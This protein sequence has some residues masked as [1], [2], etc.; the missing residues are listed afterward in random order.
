MGIQ[1]IVIS[2]DKYCHL[3]RGFWYQWAKYYGTDASLIL[4]GLTNPRQLDS[5]FGHRGIPFYSAGSPD[6]YPPSRWSDKLLKILD[7]VAEEVFVLMLEDYWLTRPVDTRAIKMIY[8]YMFQF[9]NVI[10]F[11]V[12]TERLFA[13]GGGQYLFGYNTY[14]TLGYLDLIKSDF[15]SPYHLSLWGGMWRRD[16]LR[17]FLVIGETAQQ[18]ELNGTHRLAQVGD[19]LLVLGTR[20]APLKHANVVQRGSW[21]DDPMTGLPALKAA[22]REELRQRG[23]IP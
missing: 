15:G 6:D 5:K 19:E 12:T 13:N 4:C 2:S 20:Q 9:Q 22:D 18:I 3:F 1:V 16:L 8:D 10:K 23:Y 14:E 21:N 7:E 11:D 17:Q